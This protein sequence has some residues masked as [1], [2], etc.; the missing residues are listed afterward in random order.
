M[1]NRGLRLK[2]F[3]KANDINEIASK[4]SA[5]ILTNPYSQLF[6]SYVD[7]IISD[8]HKE[9]PR[10]KERLEQI[11]NQVNKITGEDKNQIDNW[12]SLSFNWGIRETS[13]RILIVNYASLEVTLELLRHSVVKSSRSLTQVGYLEKDIPKRKTW[14]TD[15]KK[16]G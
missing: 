1:L 5:I 9:V 10:A 14:V 11:E 7:K 2:D 8:F 15:Y 4:V 6:T 3:Q 16:S 12:S 13:Q